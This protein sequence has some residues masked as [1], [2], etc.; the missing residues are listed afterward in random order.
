MAGEELLA[1]IALLE[2]AIPPE[3]GPPPG[4][5]A[6]SRAT[7]IGAAFGGRDHSTVAAAWRGLERRMS[8]D[9][10][11]K[12][13]VEALSVSIQGAG[14]APANPVDPTFRQ[15]AHT[16][17]D[18]AR[19]AETEVA[20]WRCSVAASMRPSKRAFTWKETCR[21]AELRPLRPVAP[22]PPQVTDNGVALGSARR[23]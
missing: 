11:L 2:A 10:G 21:R 3:S 9:A 13:E 12:E 8:A 14:W 6:M 17:L 20:R 22:T 4:A 16:A 7:K 19:I 18:Q 1:L 23:Q 15:L 5:G